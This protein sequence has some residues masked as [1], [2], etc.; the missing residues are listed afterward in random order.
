MQQVRS[1]LDFNKCCD[2][3]V[4]NTYIPIA[5]YDTHALFGVR[6]S[7]WVYTMLSVHTDLRRTSP[8]GSY[9]AN[10]PAGQR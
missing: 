1:A 4:E 3:F 8:E 10:R 7:A 5:P 2:N 9:Q 6:T